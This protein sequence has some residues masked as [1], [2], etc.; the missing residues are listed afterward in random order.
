MI[1]ER[2][3]QIYNLFDYSFTEEFIVDILF[4]IF[5]LKDFFQY[6]VK[7]FKG[8]F[9]QLQE[10]GFKLSLIKVATRVF[11]TKVNCT[12]SVQWYITADN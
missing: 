11:F 5:T 9:Y 1:F 12:R 7:P 8:S 3:A 2:Y 10:G 4:G 6:Q